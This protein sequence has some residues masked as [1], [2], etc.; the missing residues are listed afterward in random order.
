MASNAASR[1]LAGVAVSGLCFPTKSRKYLV[2]MVKEAV[3]AANAKF[4]LIAGHTVDGKFL[5][6]EFRA[7]LKERLRGVPMEDREWKTQ[8][9][10]GKFVK[11]YARQL[12]EF[13]PVLPNGVKW[14]IA[15]AER[16]YDKPIGALIIELVQA[17]R[18]DIRIIGERQEDGFYDP[19]PKVPVQVKGFGEIR[20]LLPRRTPWFSRLLSTSM[21][22]QINAFAP[23]TLSPEP[24]LIIVG[25]TGT[26]IHLPSFDGVPAISAPAL[27]KLSEQQ[28]SEHMVGATVFRLIPNGNDGVRIVIGTHNWRTALYLEKRMSYPSTLPKAQKAVMETLVPSD[29]SFKSILWRVNQAEV[30]KRFKRKTPFTEKVVKESLNELVSQGLVKFSTRANRYTIP[31]ERRKSAHI[32]LASLREGARSI[33]HVV[34]SCFHGG[35]AGTLYATAS[36][37]IPRLAAD[38]DA[39]IENGDLIQGIAHNYMT[40]GEL[41]PIA[42]GYDKQELLNAY[43]RATWLLDIF[44]ARLAGLKGRTTM[45]AAEL[46]DA[47]LIPYLY[48]LGNHSEWN[49]W[50]K[51]ALIL[52]SFHRTLVERVTEGVVQACQDQRGVTITYT[53]AKKAVNAKIIRRGESRLVDINGI[54]LAIKHPHKARTRTKTGRIQDVTDYI[55]SRMNTHFRSVA[56]WDKGFVI[57]YV[58]NFHEAAAAVVTKYGNTVLGV[59]TGCYMVAT[60][61]E[62]KKD[63]PVDTGPAV[64]KVQFDAEGRLLYSETEF[65]GHVCEEDAEFVFTER[66]S[67]DQMMDRC[68]A[69]MKRCGLDG[70]HLPWR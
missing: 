56:K 55:W 42:N 70:L 63:K 30:K 58:A 21:Q 20:V 24:G 29:A 54:T 69:I 1:E 47:C 60:E 49:Y 48:T 18:K 33:K 41:L 2:D 10:E 68:S 12:T 67:S 15:I 36:E 23:R 43:I 26:G 37:D 65:V 25:C 39:L 9:F 66:L 46:F 14:H 38:A 32:S 52:D 19:E 5:E 61:F 64:V 50:N 16:I 31:E 17:K 22:R 45:K 51:D 13:I 6:K 59:M 8:E 34:F 27:H 11:E 62:N 28:S 35:S 40:N 3:V 44:K 57:A 4:A 7:R 53:D